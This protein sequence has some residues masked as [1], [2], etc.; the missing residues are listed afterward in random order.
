[1]K[2]AFTE[3][4]CHHR[5][6]EFS[7][8]LLRVFKYLPRVFETKQH[9][10]LLPAT[11]TGAL[12]AAL[13]NTMSTQ[14]KA[15]FI[16]SGK[17]GE[18]WGK[19]AKAYG[20][21]F[22]EITLEWGQD[23]ELDQVRDQLK[24][25]DYQALAW[26]ACETSSGAL[27]PTQALAELCQEN[28][29][30]SV[31]DG[32]TALGA[33]PMPMDEW[34][35]DVVVG[36]SQKA[37]MLPTGMSFLSLSEKAEQASSDIKRYYFDL[38]AEKKA[39]L[40][41]KTRYSSLTQF[42]IGLDLVLNEILDEVGFQKHLQ[43]IQE[44]ADYFRSHTSLALFP[45]TP[46]PSLSCLAVP[47]GLSAIQIKNKVFEE[48]FIIVAG[49]DRLKDKVLRVGHMGAMTHEELKNTAQAIEKYL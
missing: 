1:V 38:A 9:A 6:K 30:L 17:F 8:I 26:Q 23:V 49:Q 27:Q 20:L 44:R 33:V 2:Q 24:K 35:L 22:D 25:G 41:G 40:N 43:S 7:E 5:S 21:P 47:E 11:G 39:N 28:N 36:G 34:G 13:V 14:R 46:S 10:Y 18:R 32:I 4:E 15:L 29:I 42:V 19:I 12:E 45:Q 16:N 37:F 48:G 3:V 31:V